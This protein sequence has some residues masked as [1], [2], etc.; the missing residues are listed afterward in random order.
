M[1]QTVVEVDISAPASQVFE[2]IAH[3]ENFSEAVP[4]ITKVEFITEQ[5]RGAGTRFRETRLMKGREGTTEL[6]VR[7]YVEPER[8]RFVSEAGGTTWD[9]VFTLEESELG[10][11]VKLVM[12]AHAHH[13]FAAGFNRLIRGMIEKAIAEDLDAV[14]SYCEARVS[15]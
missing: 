7:E 8:V 5:R 2:C 10:T 3:I 6:E 1:T 12:D 9:S 13:I 15:A 14:K 4:H 11:R